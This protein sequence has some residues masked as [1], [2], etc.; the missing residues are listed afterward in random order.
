MLLVSSLPWLSALKIPESERRMRSLLLLGAGTEDRDK[1]RDNHFTGLEI[2]NVQPDRVH[3]VAILIK[4]A[5]E[6]LTL[7]L[8]SSFCFIQE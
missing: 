7:A 6:K 4:L 2:R 8:Y 3:S 5:G 1:R